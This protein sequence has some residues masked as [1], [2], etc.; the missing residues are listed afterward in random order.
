MA[1]TNGVID[2]DKAIPGSVLRAAP[3][4]DDI[5]IRAIEYDGESLLL[6]DSAGQALRGFTGRAR[7]S[8][9]DITPE[10]LRA[11]NPNIVPVGVGYDRERV[12]IADRN[13]GITFAYRSVRHSA[14]HVPDYDIGQTLIQ[15][16][17]A[18]IEPSAV[19]IHTDGDALVLDRENHTIRGFAF[20]K[21]AQATRV[22]DRDISTSTI[23]GSDVTTPV[24]VG[25]IAHETGSTRYY[26]V[27]TC[28]SEH[29]RVHSDR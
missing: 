4:A 1:I 13:T 8:L 12:Y 29:H 21:A 22:P 5:D 15:S 23:R 18:S 10:D 11:A 25:Q 14:F 26:I 19:A 7:D 27:D 20:K 17:E 2:D 24:N 16:A 6:L 3:G 28:R 9:K